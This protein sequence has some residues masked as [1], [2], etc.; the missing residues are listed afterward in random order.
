MNN[1]AID[2]NLKALFWPRNVAVI[3]A[4]R[5][6]RKLGY[7]ILDNILR[8]GFRGQVYP[9]N[10][11]ALT[12]LGIPAYPDI[13]DVPDN[14]DLAVIVVPV[15]AVESV[16]DA[17]GV[18]GVRAAVIITS[19]FAETGPEG[20]LLQQKLVSRGNAHGMRILGPNSVGILNTTHR[21]N[22]SFAEG[23]P[24]EGAVAVITQSG[25][26]ATAILD[27]SRVSDLGFSQF[28]SLGNTADIDEI[29]LFGVWAADHRCRVIVGYL[30]G[31]RKGRAFMS[32]ARL[33]S[34][35]K[36]VVLM[37]V[38]QTSAG[39]TAVRSHTGALAGEDRIVDAA[40]R[41]AGVVRAYSM[42]ELFDLALA[43][44]FAYA[45]LPQGR[46]I[47]VLTNAGGPGVMAVDSI[48]RYG[49]HLSALSPAAQA[50]LSKLLPKAA[51]IRNPIDLRGDADALCYQLALE[52]L[53]ADA[54][55]DGVLVL[56]TPQAVTEPEMTARA[57]IHLA[58]EGNKPVLA[59][60]MG[61]VAIARGRDMLESAGVPVYAYPER[62]VRAIAAMAAYADY[63][64]SLTEAEE[65]I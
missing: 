24:K 62:A 65:L 25:A 15:S 27:W 7:L 37:K 20:A 28:V 49:L 21:L 17:C 12:V 8:Y 39:A 3:G 52:Q 45:P 14:V 41:Q 29:D 19:G 31:I 16:V 48:E 46:R 32:A 51:S 11:K 1:I 26:L 59:A 36:P 43:L 5:D 40:F 35:Q 9:V 63:R 64:R 6:P 10:P 50:T 22:A 2:A 57:I 30:E 13:K 34:A 56:L 23:T 38:G 47:A 33:A 55:V 54:G 44:A 18:K 61:G 53:I 4:S 60:Y 42:E 58:R